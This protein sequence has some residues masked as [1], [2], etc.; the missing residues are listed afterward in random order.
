MGEGVREVRDVGVVD[1][2]EDL[3]RRGGELRERGEREEGGRKGRERGTD[4]L[5]VDVADDGVCEG[6]GEDELDASIGLVAVPAGEENEREKGEGRK[7]KERV[8]AYTA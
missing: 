7:E 4:G 6:E 5:Y 1:C 3:L 8:V 2:A